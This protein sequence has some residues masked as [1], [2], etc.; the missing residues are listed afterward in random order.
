[1]VFEEGRQLAEE[2][3]DRRALAALYGTYA[4][5]LGLVGGQSDD[6]VRYSREATRL[7][8][9][10]DDLGL[11]IAERAYLAFGC[12][13]AGRLVDGIENCAAACQRFPEDPAL[14]AEFTGYSPL[15]GILCAHAWMLALMGRL[16]DATVVCERAEQ[17]ARAHGDSEVLTWLQL[18]RVVL[19]GFRAAAAAA[20]DHARSALE[21]G[22]RS[23]TPQARMV[24]FLALGVAHRL[25]AEWNESLAALDDALRAATGGANREVEGWIRAER[26]QAFLGRGEQDRAEQEA[27]TAVTVSLAQH[28]RCDEVRGNL[29]LA[30]T[31]L[32]GANPAALVRAEQ[33][34]VRAQELIDETGAQAYQPEV[35]EYRAHLARLRGD[36]VAARD[37]IA[38]ARRRYAAMG[39]TAQVERLAGDR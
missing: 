5:V 39:A 23:S 13:F 28:S 18:P 6:Y 16:E 7:A 22:E 27:Q 35:H 15:L 1:M 14:G 24:G 34:L 8:D 19:D 9:L 30:R 25:N 4:C 21:T 2:S 12:L 36:A 20:R 31:L 3:G 29:A 37:E 26:A 33:A 17:L 38:A 11:Q 10:T 32:R